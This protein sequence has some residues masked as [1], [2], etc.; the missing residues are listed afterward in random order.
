MKTAS[1]ARAT[2]M[3]LVMKN[4]GPGD[5]GFTAKAAWTLRKLFS[6]CFVMT[7]FVAATSPLLLGEEK[8]ASGEDLKNHLT[9]KDENHGD[10]LIKME[11]KYKG[12]KGGKSMHKRI[13]GWLF[14]AKDAFGKDMCPQPTRNP[15]LDA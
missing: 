11:A 8:K 5:A 2:A 12:K 7:L 3:T 1:L 15:V 13:R 4:P 10:A 9:Q 14:G 6:A